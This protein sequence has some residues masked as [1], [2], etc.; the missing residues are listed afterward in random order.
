[1]LSGI[2]YHYANQL[3]NHPEYLDI[4]P[5]Y[6]CHLAPDQR[7]NLLGKLLRA[8]HGAHPDNVCLD[9]YINLH[10]T[11]AQW[12]ARQLRLNRQLQFGGV[13]GIPQEGAEEQIVPSSYLYGEDLR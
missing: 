4:V 12:W 2:I 8:A 11:L 13:P 9:L 7:E 1:M 10:D 3:L 6:L 5:I